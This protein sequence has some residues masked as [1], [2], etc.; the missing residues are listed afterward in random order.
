MANTTGTAG[1]DTLNGSAASDSILGL[2]GNDQ[3]NGADSND[4][5]VGGYGYDYISGGLGDDLLI[6]GEQGTNADDTNNQLNG[7]DGNDTLIGGNYIGN[8]DYLNGGNGNDSLSGLV[9]ND[10]LYGDAGNDTLDGGDGNDF[11]EGGTE[12]DSL[13]GG[14]GD[15]YF[16]DNYGNDVFDGGDGNDTFSFIT[17]TN[18]ISNVTVTGG[19]GSDTY[20]L[21][22]NHSGNFIVADFVAGINGDVIDYGSLL[23]SWN[24]TLG[25]PFGSAGFLRIIQDTV[26]TANTLIQWDSNGGG[27]SW[28]TVITLQNF[29]ASTLTTA[30]FTFP[31]PINGDP[32]SGNFGSSIADSINGSAASDLIYGLS[33]DDTI[34]GLDGNDTLDGGYGSDQLHG[35]LGDDSLIGGV[36]NFNNY[37]GNGNN[38][39][40]GDEGNDTLIGGNSF[41]TLD[42]GTGNDSLNGVDN[43]DNLT[44]GD[45]NDTLIGGYGSDQLHGGLGND[46]LIAGE[47]GTN[48]DNSNYNSLYG[49]DGNDTLIGGNY[50]SGNS[51]DDYLNGG[52][53]NDSL[54]GLAGNDQLDGGTGDDTLDGGD[55]DDSF[56]DYYGNNVFYGAAGNDRFQIYSN[57]AVGSNTLTG[58]LGVDRYE[59]SNWFAGTFSVTD[60]TVGAGGDIIDVGNHIGNISSNPFA[61][62][63]TLKLVQSGNDTLL[64]VY[65]YSQTTL[66]QAWETILTLQNITATTLTIDNFTPRIDPNG[67]AV[68]A[69]TATGDTDNNSLDGS[70]LNDSLSGLAGNDTLKGFAGN[71]TLIGGDGNDQLWGGYGDDSLVGGA[72][73]N[74][75]YG[76]AGNDTLIG[77]NDG[78][79]FSDQQGN[80]LLIGGDGTDQFSAISWNPIDISTLTGGAGRDYFEANSYNVYD[81]YNNSTTPRN[82]TVLITDFVAGANGD[83][84]NIS[85][86]LQNG[87]SIGYTNSTIGYLRLIQ[88]GN[89]AL[90]QWD[91]D[92]ES[93]S[94]YSWVTLLT[95]QNLNLTNTPLTA[96]NFSPNSS[97]ITTLGGAEDSTIAITLSSSTNIASFK[98]TSLPNGVLYS[99]SGLTQALNVNSLVTATSNAAT[100]YFKPTA[101]WSGT[102]SLQ[103]STIDTQSVESVIGT[104]TTL[105][106]L[107]V[108][109]A[110]TLIVSNVTGN[111]SIPLLIS[112]ALTDTDGS[113]SLDITIAG[114]PQSTA[115]LSAGSYNVNNDGLWHLTSSQLANLTLSTSQTSGS[116][117]LTVNAVSKEI[118]NPS[119]TATTTKTLTI[120]L[121]GAANQPPIL[122]TPYLNQGITYGKQWN[123]SLANHFSDPENGIL[124]YSSTDLPLGLS[125]SNGSLV[126]IPSSKALG[127]IYA[128][129]ITAADTGSLTETATFFVSVL[130]FDAGTL[131]LS[132]TAAET[133]TGTSGIDTISYKNMP[134]P[135]NLLPHL[136][137][138][139]AVG[140]TIAGGDGNDTLIDIENVIGSN[141]ADTL[142]D[143]SSIN[144]SIFAG[145][146]GNDLYIIS[147]STTKILEDLNS[148]SDEVQSSADYDLSKLRNIEALTLT[149]SAIKATGANKNEHLVGN[150]V[151]NILDGRAGHDIMEG[152]AGDDTYFVD[153][154]SDVIVETPPN[155]NDT[156]ISSITSLNGYTLPENVE[157]L[158][159]IGKNS[160]SVMQ[161]TGN[162]LNN[163]I[164]AS[165]GG[166]TLKGMAGNDTLIGG[167][168]SDKL[169]GGLGADSLV[170][171]SGKNVYI[172]KAAGE[173]NVSSFDHI[174]GSFN[175][176]AA[177]K[178]QLAS[179]MS[180]FNVFAAQ[181]FSINSA[182]LMEST[183][184]NALQSQFESSKLN[185]A[186]FNTTDSKTFFAIDIDGDAAFTPGDMLIDVTGSAL[187]SVTADT[188]KRTAPVAPNAPAFTFATV[189]NHSMPNTVTST[190]S[191]VTVSGLEQGATWKYSL[192]NGA[193]VTGT[194]TSFE[195]PPDTYAAHDIRVIQTNSLGIDSLD[196][197]NSQPIYA[198]VDYVTVTEANVTTYDT[199]TTAV[200]FQMMALG[201]YIYGISGFGMGDSINFHYG[202]GS[203]LTVVNSYSNDR[204]VDLTYTLNSHIITAHLT[205]LTAAQDAAITGNDLLASFKT[206]F[207]QNS[208]TA[209]NV[210]P[211]FNGTLNNSPTS[212]SGSPVVLD[213]TVEIYD[214]E[215]A[216]LNHLD[217]V[218]YGD[219]VG[220]TLTLQR[221]GGANS[222]DVFDFDPNSDFSLSNGTVYGSDYTVMGT[223]TQSG[224]VLSITFTTAPNNA[225]YAEQSRINDLLS[226]ITYQN[227]DAPT[228]GN[229]II[230]WTFND[231]NGGG[232][233]GATT[234]TFVPSP[235]STHTY[236]LSSSGTWDQAEVEA[237]ALGGH[238][239]TINDANENAW[240]ISRFGNSEIFWIGLNDA[241]PAQEGTFVWASGEPVTYTNWSENEPNDGNGDGEDY[242][243]NN[244]V[245]GWN[246]G[247][248]ATTY[249]GI[250]ELPFINAAPTVTNLDAPENYTEDT[251]LNL[252]D[253]VV[254]D[255]DSPNV[256]VT[257]TLSN[258]A[259]GSLTTAASGNVTSTYNSQ[260]GVW[261]A[262][263]AITDVNA[264]LA[265]LTFTPA[266]NFNESFTVATSVSDGIATAITE[267]KSFTGTAV[268]DAPT[269]NALFA[270]SGIAMKNQ[271]LTVDTNSISDIDGLGAF[272]YQWKKTIG[273][274]TSDIVLQQNQSSLPLTQAE[275]GAQI[276]VVVTYTDGDGTLETLTTS[277]TN[278]VAD[279]AP[280]IIS[281]NGAGTS[282]ATTGD[283]QFN[284][285]ASNYDYTISGFGTGDVLN[286][287]VDA[288][289]TLINDVLNDGNVDVQWAAN[290]VVIMVTLTGLT[291][292]QD[293]ALYSMESFNASFGSA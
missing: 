101:N 266:A 88:N 269:A 12:D 6:A 20:V 129:H 86:I 226:A 19:N 38:Q 23:S 255:S 124:T 241:A 176:G 214:T 134:D 127:G 5:L 229:A 106:V 2:A 102:T 122:T 191:V 248:D 245:G 278:V 177:D 103:Y 7:E 225:S 130:N 249:R 69:I 112:S 206:V 154:V 275:V 263:G 137:V 96:D 283:F 239:I 150:S 234:V 82:G 25:N 242:V 39:L 183:L 243:M 99:D 267:S 108:A 227:S 282:T 84:I 163:V 80:N 185:V 10:W 195:L 194:G 262:S 253:I 264:L 251:P 141:W 153:N 121:G 50:A 192:K 31:F 111:G 256:T 48:A 279:I 117:A 181:G 158:T 152:G 149:G 97:I 169:V 232:T 257:L 68:V 73:W 223:Y 110:P 224:D 277:P 118:A 171:G 187:T 43:S 47:Q 274:T 66:T 105:T 128:V 77:G 287:P 41:D 4:A 90:F 18:A 220:A 51:Q 83:Y 145:G 212:F 37:Y 161:G 75:L 268:N 89:N 44:G 72:A 198:T 180:V 22:P 162:E 188:F 63:G 265:G 91:K 13:I 165:S 147:N 230:A 16:S 139:L 204:V 98:I 222:A 155:G 210:A 167:I 276:S 1:N 219:Y 74:Q 209:N 33:G 246:D 57:N 76:D 67:S 3:I 36:D 157:N 70:T 273:S 290:G 272:T 151:N 160:R 258:I 136:S 190:S 59:L 168:K 254:T 233:G 286:F 172:Y 61:T 49:E 133:I 107:G 35:G 235:S 189:V 78:G 281:V 215:L 58:G 11:L 113:E 202:S 208:V 126:G 203:A 24:S 62:N 27:N 45:G 81:T 184:N 288:T 218:S 244:W 40:Y 8:G 186:I 238:L 17:S 197:F 228:T 29:T 293:V 56:Y 236:L 166:G 164:I 64:Q 143:S 79:Y 53:G 200:R 207:G 54:S 15:D 100:I 193:Y 291:T 125:I 175:D 182:A 170:G 156:V 201:T 30:N 211:S 146:L 144:N 231:G 95:L 250:I 259:A 148:G 94:T 120:S 46:L 252:T 85:S 196:A 60:F 138:S 205:G 140:T 28:A 42:G 123:F 247:D 284:F 260:T 9:G 34:N 174:V 104:T 271:T 114:V 237:I 179:S 199:S 109:D 52:A 21:S 285:A 142:S 289:P 292:P 93:G 159:L 14:G 115:S 26:N 132:T 280:T 116:I 119:S 178:I 55:G 131:F 213:S 87:Q 270:I 216:A 173:S 92:G 32:I 71:D 261:A 240:L 65:Q 135:T 221:F 217:G